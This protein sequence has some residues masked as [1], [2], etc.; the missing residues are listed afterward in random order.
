MRLLVGDYRSWQVPHESTAVTV[1]VYDGVHLGHRAV[2]A[3]LGAHS[4]D[5]PQVVVTFD[6]HPAAITN[7]DNVPRLIATR[8]QTIEL[9][10]LAGADMVALLR[11]DEELRLMSPDAF[12]ATVL[13]DV[14]HAKVVVVGNDFRFGF[15]RSGNVETLREIGRGSGLEVVGVELRGGDVPHSSGAIRTALAQGDVVTAAGVLGRLFELR[16]TVVKGDGR[17]TSI[18]FPT[19]N[20]AVPPAQIVPGR[21]VYAV[22]VRMGGIAHPAVANLGVRPT[23][24]GSREVVEVHLLDF[25]GDLY[26]RDVAVEFV[27]RLRPEQRFRSVDDLVA[28]I[29]RD[30]EEARGLLSE[31]HP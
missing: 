28:Q 1:G 27:A 20:L 26:G 13:V 6:I 24:G 2:L 23:F 31:A 3:E 22:S 25:E 18:G 8:Q 29:G 12:V 5:L 16:A 11:F 17:G 14:L 7:P 9:L 4:G 30:V 19:A 10:A 15:N 21:G